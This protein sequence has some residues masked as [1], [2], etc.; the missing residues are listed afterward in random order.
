MRHIASACACAANCAL[1]LRQGG[2]IA[3]RDVAPCFALEALY[4][5]KIERIQDRGSDEAAFLP[6]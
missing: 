6:R 2:C 1:L 5:A 4:G 3:D